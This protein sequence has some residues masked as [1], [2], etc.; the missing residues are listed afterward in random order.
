M[1][2]SN[3]N[4][5][6][7]K[8]LKVF[9]SGEVVT[10]QVI[11]DLTDQKKF[12][13][14][15][16]ELVGRGEV[17]WTET[18]RISRRDSDGNTRSETVT[19]HYRNSERYFQQEV[20]LH[21]GPG[22]PPGLH[23]LPFSLMLPP[24]L[25]SSFE[26]QHGNVRY[27]LKADIV[28][29]W[30]WNHKVKQHIMVNGILDLNLYPSAKAPGN[31]TDHKRLCCLCCK[32]GPITAAIHSNRTG[33]VPGEIIGFNAEVENSSDRLMNGSFLNLVEVVTYKAST[34]KRKEERVVAEIRRETVRGRF[35]F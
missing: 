24:N 6:F 26:G 23:V 22:L 13:K 20:V 27:F 16:L 17:H 21:Q 11:V 12:R 25:P 30:K 34:K 4:I 9:F 15:K 10:G 28:R 19:D 7:D 5:Q 29:D 35:S 3:F 31:S 8:P 14:I 1:G 32:S 18:R 33:Y 2:L